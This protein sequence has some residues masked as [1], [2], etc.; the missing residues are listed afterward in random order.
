MPAEGMVHA[1]ET[2]HEQLKPDGYLIEI[3]PNG[4]PPP[5]EALIADQLHLLDHLQETDDFIEYTQASAA[6]DEV[7]RRGLYSLER[8]V[9][10]DF[11][12]RADTVDE[13]LNFLAENWSDSIFPDQV[14][15]KAQELSV[16]TGQISSIWLTEIPLINRLRKI[17]LA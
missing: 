9:S 10:F 11:I 1:L 13:M 16:T 17:S 15:I 3:H 6:L 5:V 14:G 4:Q 8:Q 12:T 2:I 7:I